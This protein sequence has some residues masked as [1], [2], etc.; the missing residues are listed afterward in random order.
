MERK[1]E[2]GVERRERREGVMEEQRQWH[3]SDGEREGSKEEEEG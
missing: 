2:W 3:E 1:Y